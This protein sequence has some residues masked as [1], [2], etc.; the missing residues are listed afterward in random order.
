MSVDL[1][2]LINTYYRAKNRQDVAAMLA[3][4]AENAVVKDEG[5]TFEGRAAI[6]G[7]ME[8]TTARYGVTVAP[9]DIKN[10]GEKVVVGA[11]VSGNF[12]GSP[13]RLTYKFKLLA[14]AIVALEIG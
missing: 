8:E 7:W 6:R 11:L 13:A 5:E 9:S 2:E 12:P 1:P 14:S 10:S 4:F 3:C